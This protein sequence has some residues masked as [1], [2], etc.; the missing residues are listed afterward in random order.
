MDY[1]LKGYILNSTFKSYT[2]TLIE[3]ANVLMFTMRFYG[4]NKC[5]SPNKRR[6]DR[7]RK[8]KFQAKLRKHPILVP[9]PFLGPCHSPYSISMGAP[10][11]ATMEAT[12]LK[13]VHEIEE[14]IRG[15]HEQQDHSAQWAERAEKEREHISNWVIDLLDQRADLRIKIRKM[16]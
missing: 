5:K 1:Q 7:F 9:V 11:L 8:K 14:Q 13:Q 4:G 2:I 15:F 6:R 3:S 10:A 12:L 16:E